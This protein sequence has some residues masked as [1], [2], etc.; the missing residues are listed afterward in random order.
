[1]VLYFGF[2]RCPDIC[3]ASLQ[4]LSTA[5]NLL[6]EKGVTNVKFLFVSLDPDRDTGEKV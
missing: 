1:M 5:I 2:T 3:P 4:K 6:K